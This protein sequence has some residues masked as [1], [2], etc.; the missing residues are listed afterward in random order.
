MLPA[1]RIALLAYIT[2]ATVTN[3]TAIMLNGQ[4]SDIAVPPSGVIKIGMVVVS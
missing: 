4:T 3:V 1:S 2:S